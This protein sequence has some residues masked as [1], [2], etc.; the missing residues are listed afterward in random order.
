VDSTA[1]DAALLATG[2]PMERALSLW[3]SGMLLAGC[4]STQLNENTLDLASTVAYLHRSQVI[5]NLGR[6]IDSADAIPAA[7]ALTG[8]IVQVKNEIKPDWIH[9]YSFLKTGLSP[10][11]STAKEL[12]L[13][14]T[15]TWTENWNMAPVAEGEDL[16]RLRALYRYV[17]YGD[18]NDCQA[19]CSDRYNFEEDY[20][21]TYIRD[22]QGRPHKVEPVPRIHAEIHTG[23][24]YW[25]EPGSSEA[26]LPRKPDVPVQSI[27]V[28]GTRTLYTTNRGY[29]ADFIIASLSAAVQTRNSSRSVM[30]PVVNP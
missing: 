9:P 11:N 22:V 7:V 20:R 4:V 1:A 26:V 3:L 6:F 16:K 17:V 30:G 18:V 24:L 27:G 5:D 13:G 10:Q 19:R 21:N 25:S 2:N 29:F 14:F 15:D 28:Y 8:G 12:Q 23:W